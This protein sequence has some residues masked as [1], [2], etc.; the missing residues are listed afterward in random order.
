MTEAFKEYSNKVLN[1]EKKPSILKLI[2]QMK[3]KALSIT[4][5]KELVKNKDRGVEL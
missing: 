1:I 4:K 3:E 5:A 2:K